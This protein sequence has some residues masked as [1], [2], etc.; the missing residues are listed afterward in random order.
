MEIIN[1]ELH[2]SQAKT[3]ILPTGS[4]IVAMAKTRNHIR[5]LPTGKTFADVITAIKASK[6]YASSYDSLVGHGA[7]LLSTPLPPSPILKKSSDPDYA[8]YMADLTTITNTERLYIALLSFLYKTTGTIDYKDA[9]IARLMNIAS[10]D[11]DGATSEA[12]QDQAN[13]NI[14]FTIAATYDMLFDDLSNEQKKTVITVMRARL[15][16]IIAKYPNLDTNPYN[17]HDTNSIKYVL[18]S[19]LLTVGDPNF[20][21]GESWLSSVW[22]LHMTIDSQLGEDDGGLGGSSSYAWYDTIFLPYILS[23][24]TLV[25]GNNVSERSIYQ[26]IGDFLA[27]TTAPNTSQYG[28]FGDGIETTTLYS[29]YSLDEHKFL[30]AITNNQNPSWYCRVNPISSSAY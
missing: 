18:P 20:P 21:E 12:N 3:V 11:P 9:A 22:E 1:G 29:A 26:N 24:D 2:T 17:S 13:R 5:V 25:T 30:A 6:D 8:K 27:M 28:T 19:L 23:I 4:T 15:S 14:Y 7:T 16:K 10:W